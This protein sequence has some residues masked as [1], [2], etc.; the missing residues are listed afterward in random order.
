MAAQAK[1]LS[2]ESWIAVRA[3][4]TLAEYDATDCTN[5]LVGLSMMGFP[6]EMLL[7]IL[8]ETA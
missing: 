3:V 6:D 8:P 2:L 1:V 5:A 4:E 7:A